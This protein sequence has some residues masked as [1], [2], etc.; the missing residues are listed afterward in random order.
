MDV[1]LKEGQTKKNTKQ[2]DQEETIVWDNDSDIGTTE[3]NS[4]RRNT[5]PNKQNLKKHP[6]RVRYLEDDLSWTIVWPR[7]KWNLTPSIFSGISN[8]RN[9]CV[10]LNKSTTNPF[11][12]SSFSFLYLFFVL[13]LLLLSAYPVTSNQTYRLT[14][15]RTSNIEHTHSHVSTYQ[16]S[17]STNTSFPSLFNCLWI[18]RAIFCRRRN[19][20]NQE[21]FHTYILG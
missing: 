12:V 8:N 18:D 7:K 20:N 10:W 3:K 2:N 17:S 14:H 15:T 9:D 16:Y 11:A 13:V 5:K 6:K 4:K 19:D 1:N 21:L